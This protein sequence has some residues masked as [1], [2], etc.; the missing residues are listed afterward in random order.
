MKS[1]K[2]RRRRKVFAKKFLVIAFVILV[3]VLG[4]VLFF[5][6]QPEKIVLR[7]I[8]A[9][10]AFNLNPKSE[11]QKV[12]EVKKFLEKENILFEDIKRAS[13]SGILISLEENGQVHLSDVKYAEELTSLQLILKRLTMEGKRFKRLDLRYER[14][15][16]VL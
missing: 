10:L 5:L 15:I 6:Y 14:P 9:N 11:D 2:N 12:A 7:P 16:I 1:S 13:D 3:M 4:V 8:P